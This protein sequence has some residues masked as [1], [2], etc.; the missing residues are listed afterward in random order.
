MN[1]GPVQ[2]ISFDRVWFILF[3]L[4]AAALLAAGI[5]VVSTR[6][7]AS[8][9][10]AESGLLHRAAA[11]AAA[12][13]PEKTKKL[14][15]SE[16]D[17]TS[18]VFLRMNRQLKEYADAG[19][20]R[21]I[22]LIG[23]KRKTPVYGLAAGAGRESSGPIP[24]S[25][26]PA[27]EEN[28]F[29]TLFARGERLLITD[30][31]QGLVY[32]FAPVFD[33]R[34]GSV[35]AAAGVAVGKNRFL[36][37]MKT[38]LRNDAVHAAA[39]V[40]ILIA[41]AVLILIR[42]RTGEK[43]RSI[44]E[45]TETIVLGAI[46]ITLTLAAMTVF[47][48]NEERNRRNMFI[49]AAGTKA[50]LVTDAALDLKSHRLEIL[51]RFFLGSRYIDGREFDIFTAPMVRLAD[52]YAM[53]WI[54]PVAAPVVQLFENRLR[55]ID[56]PD[57]RIWQR[58]GDDPAPVPARGRDVFYPV[59]YAAPRPEVDHIAGFDIG[60]EPRRSEALKEAA[61][62]GLASATDPVVLIDGSPPDANNAS[63][64]LV[65]AP[66][67]DPVLGYMRG[68][69]L[70]VLNMD[71]FLSD[72]LG[73]RSLRTDRSATMLYQLGEG[74]PE[75]PIASYPRN[76]PA[77]ADK[78][79]WHEPL[80]QIDASGDLS[81]IQPLFAFGK[82]YA[83]V[84][85]PLPALS[86]S[87]PATIARKTAFAGAA[88]TILLCAFF[89]LVT[90]RRRTLE[91]IVHERTTAL[92]ENAAELAA[93]YENAPIITV[94]I[95]RKR[96]VRKVNSLFF[97]LTRQTKADVM[98]LPAGNALRCFNALSYPDGCGSGPSCE[99]C[100]LRKTIMDTLDTGRSHHQAE[101]TM[102][103]SGISTGSLTEMRTFLLST[104]QLSIH[105]ETMV[106]ASLLDIT[107]RKTAENELKKL[108]IEL[109]Q[110]V[111]DRTD[112][113]HRAK[114]E[115]E[116]ANRAKS[117]FLAV[118]S[119]EIRTPMQGVI[120][121]LDVL[122][123]TSLRDNQAEM[124]HTTRDS[125]LSLLTIIDDILDFSKIEAGRLELENEP[126]DIC[127]TTEKAVMI[128]QDMAWKNGTELL[129]FTDPSLCR[130]V[131][132]DAVRLRQILVNLL[133]N[134]IKFSSGP[135]RPGRVSLSVKPAPTSEFPH[136]TTITVSDNGIGMENETRMRLFAPFTQ[137]SADTTRRYGGTGLGL[138]ITKNLVR[139][140]GGRISVSSRPG[141]GSEFTIYIPFSPAPLR[142][143]RAEKTAAMDLS[144][145]R[146][147]VVGGE[148]SLASNL[149][150]Y[151][152]W[153]EMS[154]RQAKDVE[155]AC[156]L[157]EALPPGLW[158]WIIDAGYGPDP[159]DRFRNALCSRP[160]L[161]V[162]FVIIRRG[163]RRKPR[164]ESKD[165]VAMDGNAMLRNHFLLA[166]AA[167]AG[168]VDIM[169]A[170]KD[171]EKRPETVHLPRN[172]AIR[173]GRLI[174]VAEDNDTNRKV[175]I[176]QL[177]LLGYA[178]DIAATGKEAA[179]RWKNETYGL[180]LADLHMPDMDGY[181]L[182]RAIRAAETVG[183]RVPIVAFT[184]STLKNQDNRLG[185]AGF[186]DWLRKPARLSDIRR[187]L[188]KWLPE[189][190]PTF[191]DDDPSVVE[192]PPGKPPS[193]PIDLRV[194]K[195]MVGDDPDVI[196]HLLADFRKTARETSRAMRTARQDGNNAALAEQAHKL[197][198][199]ARFA[200]AL[201]LGDLCAQ[202]EAAGNENA[203]ETIKR[204]FPEF[205]AETA[206]VDAFVQ[207]H[208]K[209]RNNPAE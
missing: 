111:A 62:T 38:G 108:N 172:D 180:V 35:L 129:V 83:V 81:W 46:G 14:S 72:A 103:I 115:A 39:P 57:Y 59:K 114:E 88:I 82:S 117:E 181:Q 193:N 143:A 3:I 138:A 163:R 182:A 192:T 154:V 130:E 84:V 80:K 131:M 184:A 8:L 4:L 101:I 199:A 56:K 135:E 153:E 194:L 104:T 33:P 10:D 150:A 112:E 204:Y 134:A 185:E 32:A 2:S 203:E 107:D 125:A 69:S 137:A 41:G 127:Q 166:V 16:K 67:T 68:F 128:V 102:Q 118:M 52:V 159:A 70:A 189:A 13:D 209:N 64:V 92:S 7:D 174:L 90:R 97:D 196:A 109:E 198:S 60:S 23:A 164:M 98:S 105:A 160:E 95:D 31:T 24:G 71:G 173:Q 110:R 168:R 11:I 205:M 1:G 200:G 186:D 63:G 169:K 87:Y 116:K 5:T 27:A 161:D 29:E 119:H 126:F 151:L 100:L 45:Y 25:I 54:E 197:K 202:L 139:Q 20:Y 53:G 106:L 28:I 18:P 183:T 156:K 74:A 91:T 34:N 120:G 191:S 99:R 19:G 162:R 50:G 165:L 58:S 44:L 171:S 75:E 170:A 136:M 140:M 207:S 36:D 152:A 141:E 65:F 176:Q 40:I 155:A 76:L 79:V 48:E 6:Q 93:I 55:V 179:D 122:E 42:R 132:G 15:F 26:F 157:I 9:R 190:P 86:D 175:I 167:A 178:A 145:V 121:M 17:E 208:A 133:S 22:L 61:R 43:A 113:L 195:E 123:Q 12:V 30:E 206:R 188:K 177:R 85:R 51:S 158:V 77:V 94:L 96:R 89:L 21:K 146:C 124:V 147:M 144:G 47:S 37:P 73:P 142:A 49:Q 201:A 149:A 148:E 78:N 187:M 66:T